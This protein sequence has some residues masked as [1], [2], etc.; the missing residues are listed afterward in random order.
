MGH[1]ECKFEMEGASPT[2]RCWCQKTTVITL[3]CGIKISAVHCLVLSQST[4]VPDRQMHRQTDMQNMTA[5]TALA[6]LLAW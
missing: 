1:F 3:L 2:N 4:H 6:L 5:N